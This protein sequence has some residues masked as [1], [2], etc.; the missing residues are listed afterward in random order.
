[1][2]WAFL[3]VIR[4]SDIAGKQIYITELWFKCTK[5]FH[6]VSHILPSQVSKLSWLSCK[7][8]SCSPLQWV[9]LTFSCKPSR[10]SQFYMPGNHIFTWLLA[11]SVPNK[12]N[13][14]QTEPC[15]GYHTNATQHTKVQYFLLSIC[16]LK[17]WRF[18]LQ[19]CLLFCVSLKLCLSRWT[20]KDC[21]L[22]VSENNARKNI[23]T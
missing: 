15:T 17:T 1:M 14:W 23:W 12:C 21:T 6:N 4:C 5:S 3:C 16:H 8:L 18:Q 9:Y 10:T 19:F 13:A 22:I 7:K 20:K 2:G 11:I